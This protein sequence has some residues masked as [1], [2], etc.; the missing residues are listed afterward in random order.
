MHREY[1]KEHDLIILNRLPVPEVVA[2]SPGLFRFMILDTET[3]GVDTSKDDLIEL[4]YVI[5]EFNSAGELLNL[6]KTYNELRQPDLPILNSNIHGI[7]D[8]DCLGKTIDWA[9]VA[10]DVDSCHLIA[11]HNARFDRRIVERYCEAFIP[12][13]WCC[14]YK[15][16]DYSKLGI[17]TQKLDYLAY[18]AGFHFTAHRALYDVLATLEVIKRLNVFEE[19]LEAAKTVSYVVY[20]ANAPFNAKDTLKE[21]GYNA[22]YV[23]GK[24]V[25]WYT[26]VGANELDS[27][28]EWLKIKIGCRKPHFLEIS[29]K[30]RYS[31][32]ED[33]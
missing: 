3:T 2:P 9:E 7:T 19:M 33:L 17:T 31:V 14:S 13:A 15:D 18:K 16:V 22:L 29:S 5:V 1:A 26:I 12:V 20:A 11:A 28:L 27:T 21:A 23:R 30:E 6:V 25:N 32:R 24:F 10:E 4:A 8:E